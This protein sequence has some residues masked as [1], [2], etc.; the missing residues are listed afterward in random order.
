MAPT[1]NEAPTPPGE[2]GRLDALR[3]YRILDTLHEQAYDDIVALARQICGTPQAVMTFI[4]EERQW[5]KAS[6]GIA[7]EETER[8]IAFC[9]VAIRDLSDV[10][11]VNDAS[12]HPV[13][14]DYPQVTG[15]D[16]LRFYAGAPMVTPDGFGLGTVCVVDTVPRQLDGSQIDALRALA[17]LAVQMLELRR[18][19]LEAQRQLAERELFTSDLL[20]YQHQLEEQNTELE[21]EAS[22]DALTGLLNRTGLRRVRKEA[23]PH[24]LA[25]STPYSVAVLDVDH[26][27]RINDSLGHSAG[28]AV[29]RIVGEEISRGVRSGDIAVRYGGEEFL[30]FMPGTLL[31]GARAV[32]ER[33]RGDIALRRDLPMPVTVSAGLAMGLAGQDEPESIFQ[34]A[35]QALYQAKRRGRDQVAV[36]ED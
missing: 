28:D 6:K 35:D 33:I 20:R 29:L 10:T 22:T 16:H 11:V 23:G 15:P 18:A 34:R 13:F 9:D 32:V 31:A 1:I 4:D 7:G 17:R 3:R 2:A 5:F 30:V 19:Q 24:T 27:K 36:S 8:S 14:Q 26:F 25:R 21:V 12:V